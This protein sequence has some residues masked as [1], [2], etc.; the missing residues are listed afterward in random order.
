MNIL[1]FFAWILI[2]STAL[3]VYCNIVM[4]ITLI[5]AVYGW[6]K[7]VGIYVCAYVYGLCI[8]KAGKEINL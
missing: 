3:S 4:D 8:V 2:G 1:R 6:S 5:A 7:L